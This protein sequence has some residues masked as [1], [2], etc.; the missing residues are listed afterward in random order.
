MKFKTTKK[1][2][3]SNFP[4]ILEVPYCGLRTLLNYE[5]PCAY[6]V[7]REGWACDIYDM[8][9]FAISTG[10]APFGN[11]SI[12]YKELQE[13][14]HKAQGLN[15]EQRKKLVEEFKEYVYKTFLERD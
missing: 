4:L 7:R 12:P 1:E 9:R 5:A 14:E 11:A 6:T 10:Y 2:I 13:W 15:Y 3:R 8:G